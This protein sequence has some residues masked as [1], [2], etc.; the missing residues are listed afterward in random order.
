MWKSRN[1]DGAK[2]PYWKHGTDEEKESRLNHHGS[3]TDDPALP[4]KLSA[5]RQDLGYEPSRMSLCMLLA[6]SFQESR[7]REIR[8][9]GFEE[10][11]MSRRCRAI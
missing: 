9:S 4:V 8:M 5:L 6:E 2:G 3:P 7:M 1:G 10:G 11:G